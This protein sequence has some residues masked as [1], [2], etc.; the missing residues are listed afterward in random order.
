MDALSSVSPFSTSPN[1]RKRVESEIEPF[2]FEHPD[3]R[4]QQARP[5][6]PFNDPQPNDASDV[7][8][9]SRACQIA[10]GE[11]SEQARSKLSAE[12]AIDYD[13]LIRT[14]IERDE[15]GQPIQVFPALALAAIQGRDPEGWAPILV[16]LGASFDIQRAKSNARAELFQIGAPRIQA[17]NARLDALSLWTL[18]CAEATYPHSALRAIESVRQL[19]PSGIGPLT[20]ELWRF[21]DDSKFD[22]TTLPPKSRAGAFIEATRDA[23]DFLT[24]ILPAWISGPRGADTALLARDIAEALSPVD[25]QRLLASISGIDCA[26]AHEFS[27][28]ISRFSRRPIVPRGLA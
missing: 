16:A 10:S 15:R 25:A 2:I 5:P 13:L 24:Q 18:A 9:A 4:P 8:S 6:P 14:R 28:A 20:S 26:A 27:A 22:K 1:A 3:P 19:A 21:G 17:K 12:I 23:D 7:S 11:A